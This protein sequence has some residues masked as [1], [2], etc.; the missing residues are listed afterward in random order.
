VV[1]ACGH[2]RTKETYLC[3]KRD[4]FMR[5]KRPIYAAKE[6]YLCGKR[7]LFMRQ[8][9]PIYAAKE[10]Y[11]CGKRDMQK[12]PAQENKRNPGECLLDSALGASVCVVNTNY[13]KRTHS[14]V[15]EHN[16]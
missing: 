9:K 1:L 12:R 10:T 7:N 2:K 16:L 15:R 3:G 11:L 13:S 14:I 5:Q 8:K 6:T 4:L